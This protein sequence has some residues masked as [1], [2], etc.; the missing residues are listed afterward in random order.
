M[1]LSSTAVRQEQQG[2]ALLRSVRMCKRR[3]TRVAMH[4]QAGHLLQVLTA[5]KGA[6]KQLG[7]STMELISKPYHD[8]A[9]MGLVSPTA[10]IFVPCRN[11]LS[12]HPDEYSS[13]KNVVDGVR[14]LALTLAALA[15]SQEP[16]DHTEL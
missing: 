15:G 2:R 9:F 5:I 10:M 11:G 6:A 13:P 7:V 16:S 8:A 1:P 3:A 14:T 12:H 4:C